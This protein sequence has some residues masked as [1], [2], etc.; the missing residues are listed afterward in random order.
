MNLIKRKFVSVLNGLSEI[1]HK[2]GKLKVLVYLY[3]RTTCYLFLI[4][5]FILTAPVAFVLI[6]LRPFKKIHLVMLLSSRIG[7]F[8][9]NTEFMLL[10]QRAELYSKKKLYLF[11]EEKI[12]CN[13][14]L[15]KMWKRILPVLPLPRILRGFCRK[16][17]KTLG[18]LL[19]K[20]YR[21]DP[22]KPFEICIG[23]DYQQLLEKSDKPHIYFT[24]KEIIKAK[25]IMTSMGVNPDNP[26]VC[27]LVRDAGYLGRYAPGWTHHNCRNADVTHYRKAALF[28]AEKGYTVFRMGKYV[29]KTF[30][31]GHPNV[32]DYANHPK[33]HDLL[34]IY[35]AAHCS[36]MI[37][38]STGL[39]GVTQLFR[40]PILTT[41]LL[42]IY[43][44]LGF[45]YPYVLYI[46]KKIQCTD[47]K[48][49]LTFK[50]LEEKFLDVTATGMQDALDKHHA[51]ILPN[52]EEE[53]LD[54][55]IEMEA[56]FRNVWVETEEN[57]SFQ[58]KLLTDYF[59]ATV[60]NKKLLFS[61]EHIKVKIGYQFWKEN[62]ELF[63]NVEEKTP[64]EIQ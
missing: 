13:T 2:H 44:Q 27:L 48:K 30:D 18:I 52:T 36:F 43:H 4:T 40:K 11:Y 61:L 58:K 32:I 50:E 25:K 59:P 7:H 9:I 31:V 22:I 1:K 57:E 39:D 56:R 8:T 47:T 6:A 24:T 53:I 12:V 63:F 42:P 37:T 35:L 17:D 20:T 10:T 3:N 62:K 49:N 28:L 60:I 51:R 26:F 46:P 29:E 19:G 55:V 14:Q 5:N 54:A 38:T 41:N 15:S 23:Q 33:K 21:N 34:D 16:V 64:I 45:W